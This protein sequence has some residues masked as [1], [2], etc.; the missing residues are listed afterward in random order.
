[1]SLCAEAWHG[2]PA[3]CPFHLSLQVCKRTPESC[4]AAAF[5]VDHTQVKEK[6]HARRAT[7]KNVDRDENE[8]D[9]LK[10]VGIVDGKRGGPS[11]FIIKIPF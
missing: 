2:G 3:G 6:P 8:S 9:S 10:S 1:M 5:I 4:T 11:V 7:G